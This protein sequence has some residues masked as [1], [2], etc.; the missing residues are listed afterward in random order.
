MHRQITLHCQFGK[1][2]VNENL[3]NAEA[4]IGVD[5][6]RTVLYP[7][8]TDVCANRIYIREDR[9]YVCALPI[10]VWELRI[11]Y[12]EV[13]IYTCGPRIY[14]CEDRIYVFASALP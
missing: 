1:R 9:I 6:V 5:A 8:R 2:A 12:C 14:D 3:Q 13:S 7:S 11:Y 10:Y 4:A